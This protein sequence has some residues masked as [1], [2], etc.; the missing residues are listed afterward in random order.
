MT[1]WPVLLLALSL[2]R[3]TPTVAADTPASAD[4]W[5]LPQLMANMKGVRSGTAK[6]VERRFVQMLKE[7]LLSSGRLVYVAPDRLQKE[8]LA[9]ARSE[10][11]AVG[12]RL[13]IQQPDGMTRELSLT[14]IPEIGGLVESI[15][16]TLAGDRATLTRY[17]VCTLAGSAHA[18]LLQLEPRD[19]R[20]RELVTIVRI[21]GDGTQIR[22]IQTMEHD[23]DRTEMTITP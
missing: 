23:G 12:D 22:S 21:W 19:E 6:F 15:R 9:P 14:E 7:P 18:W 8:T 11:S 13:T 5:G 17:F 4:G 3:I 1:R 10:L 2:V 16:A 20:L